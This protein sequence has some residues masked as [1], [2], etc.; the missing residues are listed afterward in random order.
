LKVVNQSENTIEIDGI[1]QL[2]FISSASSLIALTSEGL[3][4]F[5]SFVRYDDIYS[6]W[7]DE[8]DKVH[9]NEKIF[10]EYGDTLDVMKFIVAIIKENIL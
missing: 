3:Y 5:D 1:V 10:V 2:L 7:I 4:V 9:I 6:I 8:D